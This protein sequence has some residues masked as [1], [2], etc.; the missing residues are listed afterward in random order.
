MEFSISSFGAATAVVI[1]VLVV[2]WVSHEE[3]TLSW[4]YTPRRKLRLSFWMHWANYGDAVCL[5]V[6][7]WLFVPYFKPSFPEYYWILAG[8][9]L[10]TLAFYVAWWLGGV[11]SFILIY[12]DKS[13]EK[14]RYA[15]RDVTVAGWLHAVFTIIIISVVWSYITTKV[16]PQVIWGTLFVFTIYIPLAIIQPGLAECDW[17][18]PDSLKKAVAVAC[19]SGIFL[20]AL[21]FAV[22]WWKLYVQGVLQ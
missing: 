16:F 3:D 14:F 4:K 11:R 19:G 10:I 17:K 12:G 22:T 2:G 15:Y 20:L 7:V 21:L 18:D 13:G 9:T 6:F 8:S 1:Y 5:P